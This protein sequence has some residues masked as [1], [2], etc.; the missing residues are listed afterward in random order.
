MKEMQNLMNLLEDEFKD[1]I[2]LSED[3]SIKK[4]KKKLGPLIIK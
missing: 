1:I 3:I 4:G 2:K